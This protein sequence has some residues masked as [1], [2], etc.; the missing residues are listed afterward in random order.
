MVLRYAKLL[1]CA[2]AI[3]A[4]S[5]GD[6]TDVQTVISALRAQDFQRALTLAKEL[7]VQ[8]APDPR[9]LTLE[10]MANEGLKNRAE[11]L[12]NYDAALRI[13]PDYLPALKAKAQL[14]YATGDTGAEKSLQ[15]ILK[16][17][18]GDEVSHAMVAALDYK[19]GNCKSA[20]IEYRQSQDAIAQKADALT[21]YGECLLRQHESDQAA[22]VLRQAVLVEPDQWWTRYNLAVA[23]MSRD[24]PGEAVNVLEPALAGSN[25]QPDMLDLAAQANEASGNTPR[26]V[27]LFRKAILSQPRQETYYLHFADLCF[28]HQSFRVGVD[29]ID[30]GLTQ[31]PK[32]AK[33]H[34]ARGILRV[35]LGDFTRA[36]NDFD[37]ADRLNGNA[38]ISGA[39]ASLAELQNSNLDKALQLARTTLQSNPHDPM[40][41]YVKAET[42]KQMGVEP[43]SAEFREA[44]NSAEFAVHLKPDFTAARNLLGSL[45]LR[46][47]DVQLA[48]KQFEAILKLDPLDETAIYHL[49]QIARK[50][51]ETERVTEFMQRLAQA[52]AVQRQKDEDTLRYRLVE[53][54]EPSARLR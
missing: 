43:G 27:E 28:D 49:L 24:R 6:A 54:D 30:A 41:H 2:V 23:E 52:R 10:G 47:N 42:L 21:Q 16:L 35:Q 39:A 1:L 14:E 53:A 7:N 45:Y 33:L 12:Q 17:E 20:V 26:A 44:L 37:T 31:L 32:S 22:N 25:V 29:M 50:A 38:R 36:E 15:Q 11:A 18:P 48:T 13:K 51:G 9:V 46:E 3:V 5:L 19:Q 40:L 8:G 34:L 4:A